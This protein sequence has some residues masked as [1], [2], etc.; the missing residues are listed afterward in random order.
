ML[1]APLPH[2]CF[3]RPFRWQHQCSNIGGG[4][5]LAARED[6]SG[7]M[8]MTGPSLPPLCLKSACPAIC[9]CSHKQQCKGGLI[10][11]MTVAPRSCQHEWGTVVL[12]AAHQIKARPCP[13]YGPDPVGGP[14]VRP[15]NLLQG[16]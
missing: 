9:L 7:G 14:A 6:Q 1:T 3:H 12:G 16:W 10:I 5:F 2:G 13:K 15:I 11:L 4:G 8:K